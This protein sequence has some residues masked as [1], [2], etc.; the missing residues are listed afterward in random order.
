MGRWSRQELED[1][2]E[3][4]QKVG[5]QAGSSGDWN[6]WAE[7]FTDDATY[8]EHLFGTMHGREEIRAWITNV[9]STWPGNAMPVFP[10]GWYIVDEERGWIACEILNRMEDPGDGSIH[11]AANFTLLK[12]GGEGLWDYEEDIYNPQTFRDMIEVWSKRKAELSK[13]EDA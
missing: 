8:V 11:Q 7:L 12:Y 3:V 6:P 2:F 1:A 10:I 5:E 13:K 9:M 4:Y